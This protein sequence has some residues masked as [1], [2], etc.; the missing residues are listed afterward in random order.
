M[1]HHNE[2]GDEN[3]DGKRGKRNLQNDRVDKRD[4]KRRKS[5]NIFS[6]LSRQKCPSH[7]YNTYDGWSL[8]YIEV[9]NFLPYEIEIFFHELFCS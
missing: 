7:M 3:N 5:K 4:S 2:Q 8:E 6:R 1:K 9:L